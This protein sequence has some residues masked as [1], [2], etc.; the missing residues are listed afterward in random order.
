LAK[1]VDPR[2]AE[3]GDPVLFTIDVFN[4][5]NTDALNVVLVDDIPSFLD[6]LSVTISPDL[7]QPI[8]IVGNRITIDFGTVTPSDFFTVR[9]RTRVNASARPPGGENMVYLTTSSVDDDLTNN[10]DDVEVI[11]IAPRLPGTGFAPFKRTVLPPQPKNSLYSSYSGMWLEIPSMGVEMP[12]VGVPLTEDGWDVTWLWDNAGYLNY[13]A[14]PTWSGNTGITGHVTLPTGL[15]GPFANLKQLRWGDEI[16]IHAWGLRY[17]YEVRDVKPVAPGDLSVLDHKEYD[18]VTL[19]TCSNFSDYLD[20][21]LLRWV[22]QAVL[23][24]VEFELDTLNNHMM[25]LP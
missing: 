21:Y 6:I 17:S 1:S 13:T 2:I 16:V 15:P 20:E 7:G 10:Q 23:M 24:K 12:I 14:F 4:N 11:I 9:I 18:W 8:T 25:W 5:G 3:I 22:A 19:I